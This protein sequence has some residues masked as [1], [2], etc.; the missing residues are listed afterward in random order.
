M[1]VQVELEIARRVIIA[2]GILANPAAKPNSS[3]SIRDAL[4]PES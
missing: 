1:L 4:A 2:S 3:C